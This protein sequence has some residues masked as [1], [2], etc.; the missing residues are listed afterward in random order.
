MYRK[1]EPADC[2]DIYGLICDLEGTM[3]PKER[4]YG[5]FASQT[6]D[7]R[8]YC[9]LSEEDGRTVGVLNLRFEDQLHHAGKIAEIM[10]FAVDKGFRN[11]G[12]GKAMIE[13]AR[14]IAAEHGCIRMEA[15]CN[16][17]R[18][19]THRFYLREGFR[20]FHYKFSRPLKGE[21]DGE[22]RLGK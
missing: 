5:I 9:L 15:A 17:L 10:E 12:I 20:N 14:D 22:N 13:K 3:L 4:F 7:E 6:G 8:Y 18:T 19:D 11:K 2:D 16:Q 21:N 1:A